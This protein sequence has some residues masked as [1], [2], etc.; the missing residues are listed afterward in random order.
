MKENRLKIGLLIKSYQVDAWFAKTVQRLLESDYAQVELVILKPE[1]PGINNQVQLKTELV[2]KSKKLCLALT[3]KVAD[4]TYRAL[5][6]KH[7]QVADARARVD[8]RPVLARITGITPSWPAANHELS[9]HDLKTIGQASLDVIICDHAKGLTDGVLTAARHGI[10]SLHHTDNQISRAGAPSYWQSLGDW[11]ES[12]GVM[13]LKLTPENENDL[14]LYRSHSA[15]DHMAF[16]HNKNAEYWKASTFVPRVLNELYHRGEQ[17]FYQ[18]IN[19]DNLHPEF[20]TNRAFNTPTA[21]EKFKLTGKKLLDKLNIFFNK[22]LYYQQWFLLYDLKPALSTSFRRYKKIM[23]PRDRFWAD[24]HIIFAND[25]YYIFIE[26]FMQA[27]KKGH[28]SVIEMDRQ[29]NYQFPVKVLEKDHHLSYPYVFMVDGDYYMIP[30]TASNRTIELYKS[31]EFPFKWQWQMN[32]MENV[33][34]VDTTLYCHQGKWWLFANMVE[35]RGASSMDELFIFYSDDFRTTNWQAHRQNPVIS[36]VRKARP[37][38]AIFEMNGNLYRPSQNCAHR[39][40]Y[41]FNLNHITCLTPEQYSEVTVSQVKPNW[42]KNLLATH[43]FN[44]TGELQIIDVLAN[45]FKLGKK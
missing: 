13:L 32:L 41:G 27:S 44:K 16:T 10:W 35:T 45:K 42:H 29:G 20:N 11:S 22:S 14:I 39:Y 21:K 18:R 17:A 9:E 2:E 23:P 19:A 40:G 24:P 15:T 8:L 36:D 3:N 34:A 1:N 12:T 26:E 4:I 25:K 28:I 37:A 7:P 5:M 43:T 30:E 6:E 31:S 38:G 33:Y